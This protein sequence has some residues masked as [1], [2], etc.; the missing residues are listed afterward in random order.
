MK[1]LLQQVARLG[2]IYMSWPLVRALKRKYPE[3]EIHFLTRKRFASALVGLEA[4][5]KIHYLPTQ[6]IFE[7]LS[8]A[9]ATAAMSIVDQ[10]IADLRSEG[11]NWI[12]NLTFS[13][14]SSYVTSLIET[15]ATKVSGYSRYADGSLRLA[16][17]VSA[18]FY[19]QV[20]L[21]GDNRIHL[22]D[23]FSGMTDVQYESEDYAPPVASYQNESL[24]QD[25]IVIHIGA[26]EAHKSLSPDQWA[27][28]VARWNTR[29]ADITPVLIGAPSEVSI[30]QKIVGSAGVKKC[31]NLVGETQLI[32]LFAIIGKAHLL[33]GC[34]SA[35]IHMATLTQTPTYNISTGIVNFWETGPKAGLSFIERLDQSAVYSPE[36]SA[37]KC[38]ALLDGQLNPTLVVRAEGLCSYFDPKEANHF[39]WDLIQYIYMGARPP[40]VE[41]MDLLKAFAKLAEANQAS[42][43]TLK[44]FKA[45]QAKQ[46][47]DL[48]DGADEIMQLI[49]RKYP[50]L[51]PIVRWYLAEKVKIAPGSLADIVASTLDVHLR[52]HQLLRPYLTE[53]LN[54]KGAV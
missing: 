6:D 51:R 16:D 36:I 20:G 1:I 21:D 26:S 14:V 44:D 34:D 24:P 10:F 42:V 53:D 8:K 33:I 9:N 52:F 11:F 25:Y 28:F 46:I 35:P 38:A 18:Y 2:D 7:T 54:L 19:A 22:T 5:D 45:A 39:A 43:A 13:P 49:S 50:E 31:I 32:D 4:V 3:A 17:E 37:E 47:G 48:L 12:I 40:V 15:A 41:R 23:L 27:Q 30:G 29:R